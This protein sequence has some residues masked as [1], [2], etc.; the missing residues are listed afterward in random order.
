MPAK[1]FATLESSL[2]TRSE[3]AEAL[4]SLL[5]PLKPH[6]T[7][8]R[9]CVKLGNT[10]TRYDEVGAQL[11]GFSRPM[12]GLA[13]L[14]AGGEEYNGTEYW[15]EG[16]RNGTNPDHPEFWGWMQDLDQ[17]VRA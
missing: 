16:L 14:L 10:A 15:L 11:E 5:D 17:R 4:Q 3:V 6:F 13:S 2:Y 8:G 9:T 12:W 7:P 1:T